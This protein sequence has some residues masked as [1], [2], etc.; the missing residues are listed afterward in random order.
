MAKNWYSLQEQAQ[1]EDLK[2]D[3]ILVGVRSGKERVETYLWWQCV[4]SIIQKD[5]CTRKSIDIDTP[6]FCLITPG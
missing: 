5:K 3:E 1:S 2:M 6:L 4:R